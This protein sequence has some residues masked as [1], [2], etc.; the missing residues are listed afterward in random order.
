MVIS[1]FIDVKFKVFDRK[2]LENNL[3][4]LCGMTIFEWI[5]HFMLL[6]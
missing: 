4:G 2:V 5:I 6:N 1:H 3:R